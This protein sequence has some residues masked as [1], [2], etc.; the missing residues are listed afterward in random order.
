MIQQF[1][2]VTLLSQDS[3]LI[4]WPSLEQSLRPVMMIIIMKYIVRGKVHGLIEWIL[5]TVYLYIKN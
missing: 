2:Q 4:S 1:P 5:A 3:N